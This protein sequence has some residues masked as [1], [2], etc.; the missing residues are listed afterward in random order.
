MKYFVILLTGLLSL[1]ALAV[2]FTLTNNNTGE[3]FQYGARKAKAI[4]ELAEGSKK[5]LLE[6]LSEI[7][8]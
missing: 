3:R 2:S 5:R 6:R 7:R 8:L 1:Q 4:R